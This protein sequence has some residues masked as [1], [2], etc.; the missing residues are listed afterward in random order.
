MMLMA[1]NG[2]FLG[3]IPH[4][5]HKRSEIKAILLAGSTSMHSLPVRTTGQDFLHSCR[6][7]LGLHLSELTMAIL[8]DTVSDRCPGEPFHKWWAGCGGRWAVSGERL[9]CELVRH[10]A[11]VAV[12]AVLSASRTKGAEEETADEPGT[13]YT[14]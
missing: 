9:P 13:V 3:Q 10:V 4:P 1:S 12:N 14:R 6:H 5:M 7:F 2:H 11:E 8:R